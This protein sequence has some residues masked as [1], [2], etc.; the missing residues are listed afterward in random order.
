MLETNKI[1]LHRPSGEGEGFESR[2]LSFRG[3]KTQGLSP[4]FIILVVLL[5]QNLTHGERERS[6]LNIHDSKQAF[7][8]QSGRFPGFG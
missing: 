7:Y 5:S 4:L 3:T 2:T 8:Y 1:A 6:Q